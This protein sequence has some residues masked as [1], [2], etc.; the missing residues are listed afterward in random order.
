MYSKRL[1]LCFETSI[2]AF[3]EPEIAQWWGQLFEEVK[4]SNTR[5]FNYPDVVW[6][7]DGR[8][9]SK[10]PYMHGNCVLLRGLPLDS[11][12]YQRRPDFHERHR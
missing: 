2:E 12:R 7:E 10:L 11:A 6:Q 4:T 9:D 8:E 3:E 1:C 5:R